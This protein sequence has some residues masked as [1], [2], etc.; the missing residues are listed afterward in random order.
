MLVSMACLLA[1]L[2][3]RVHAPNPRILREFH[4]VKAM[5]GAENGDIQRKHLWHHKCYGTVRIKLSHPRDS[6]RNKG[7][8]K[9]T[10]QRC[11]SRN[12]RC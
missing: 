2:G 11:N 12:G 8:R 5:G 7:E 6:Q 1:L 9:T 10:C 4:A 3:W